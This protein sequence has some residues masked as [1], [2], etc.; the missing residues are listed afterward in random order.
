MHCGSGGE[1]DGRLL[2]VGVDGG[3]L[4]EALLQ[5]VEIDI[6][7]AGRELLLQVDALG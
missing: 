3:V 7:V 6:A 5:G 2:I 4:D 1:R